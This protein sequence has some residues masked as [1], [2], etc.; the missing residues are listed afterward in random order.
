M[1]R[2]AIKRIIGRFLWASLAPSLAFLADLLRNDRIQGLTL[3]GAYRDNEVD[4]AHPLTVLLRDLAAEGLAIPQ[5]I[6]TGLTPSDTSDL[7][8]DMLQM[9]PAEV[10][11]LAAVTHAKTGGNPFY[12]IEFLTELHRDGVLVLAMIYEG[13]MSGST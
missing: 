10:A 6:L 7:L 5:L 13:R 12:T 8:A 11:S 1:T 9:P 3:I 2:Q 4:A